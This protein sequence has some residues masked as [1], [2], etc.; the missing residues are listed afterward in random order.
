MAVAG[1]ASAYYNTVS[2]SLEG[3]E[4]EYGIYTARTGYSD[5]I[6]TF[7][8]RKSVV[9]SQ[10]STRIGAPITA[11]S[12]DLRFEFVVYLHIASTSAMICEV[13]KPLRSIA[14]DGHATVQAPHPWQTAS[15]TVATRLIATVLSGIRN[16]LS[17]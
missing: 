16:S 7:G 15:L 5:D 14:P 8:V 11:E 17:T 6:Y 10:V 12:H 2:A 4:D 9:S 13:A 1:V 3:T